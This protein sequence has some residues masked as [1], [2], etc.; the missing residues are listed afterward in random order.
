MYRLNLLFLLIILAFSACGKTECDDGK[1]GDFCY[2]GYSYNRVGESEEF[3]LYKSDLLDV[4]FGEGLYYFMDS[5][6]IYE[7]TIPIHK[8]LVIHEGKTYSVG[9]NND[10]NLS[11]SKLLEMGYPYTRREKTESDYV[12]EGELY[13]K[14]NEYKDFIYYKRSKGRIRA[15][16]EDCI[17]IV[18][19]HEGCEYSFC[20]GDLEYIK[21]K[22][23][24]YD[25]GSL[26]GK[27]LITFEE[28]IEL[29]YPV[30]KK[31]LYQ[32]ADGLDGDRCINNQSYIKIGDFSDY[33]IYELHARINI[34]Y[35]SP[36]I[37]LAYITFPNETNPRTIYMDKNRKNEILFI[38]DTSY[39]GI[40]S[41][42]TDDIDFLQELLTIK[43]LE[44]NITEDDQIFKGL[45]YNKVNEYNGYELYRVVQEGASVACSPL[46]MEFGSDEEYTYYKSSICQDYLIKIDNDIYDVYKLFS[47][48]GITLK[49]L[50]ELKYPLVGVAL[51]NP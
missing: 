12:Y 26:I 45:L 21:Y 14:V 4:N 37:E 9:G 5:E 8:H 36:Y 32:C 34:L 42:I 23:K 30:K 25:V 39:Y 40:E 15:V 50:L 47:D 18:N 29:G 38:N 48:G 46:L 2:E 24:M 43:K 3:K 49:E 28:L 10:I 17:T 13:K 11:H 19:E 22:D 6:F 33:E 35:P 44:L 16:I 27:G 7:M 1:S 20:T 31:E 51:D 41:I